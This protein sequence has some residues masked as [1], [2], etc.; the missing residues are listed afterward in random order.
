MIL[1][2]VFNDTLFDTC[3]CQQESIVVM[4]EDDSVIIHGTRSLSTCIYM[5]KY[6]MRNCVIVCSNND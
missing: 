4:F 6:N 2:P 3:K 1:L 5:Y